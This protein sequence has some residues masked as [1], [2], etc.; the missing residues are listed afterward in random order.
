MLQFNVARRTRNFCRQVGHLDP[1]GPQVPV[2]YFARH[3]AVVAIQQGAP[4][5]GFNEILFVR[6]K[7]FPQALF[8]LFGQHMR[9]LSAP[10][11]GRVHN[12]KG[13]ILHAR[14]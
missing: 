8:R 6:P 11:K 1:Q 3:R 13:I 10:V 14:R 9:F 12:V 7:R 4:A 5:E 2:G